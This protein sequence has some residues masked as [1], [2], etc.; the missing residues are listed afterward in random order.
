MTSGLSPWLGDGASHRPTER[1]PLSLARI[2][3][4]A[5]EILG[6][7]GYDA[8]TMRAVAQGLGTGAASLYA[9]VASKAHLDQLM[10]D[11]V[12]AEIELPAPDPRRWKEQLTELLHSMRRVLQSHPGVSRAAMGNVPLGPNSMAMAEAMLGIVR[13]GGVPDRVAAFTVD[14]LPLYVSASTFE[15]TI[16]S[17][18]EGDARARDEQWDQIRGYFA[19]LPADRFPNV[20]ALA[21]ALVGG[22][23]DERFAFGVDVLVAGIAAMA[24]REKASP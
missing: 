6:S 9:H 23:G 13:A 2:V 21:G 16:R 17:S 10:I 4:T 19:A 20:V 8:V 14:V 7:R 5:L 1:R 11:R 15:D 22:D 24:E 3:D 12:A 18:G